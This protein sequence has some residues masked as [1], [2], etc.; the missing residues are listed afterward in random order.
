MH[1]RDHRSSIRVRKRWIERLAIQG[2]NI[3]VGFTNMT[4]SSKSGKMAFSDAMLGFVGV[5]SVPSIG[6]GWAD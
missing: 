3:R 1:D 2:R 6:G 4:A 5:V